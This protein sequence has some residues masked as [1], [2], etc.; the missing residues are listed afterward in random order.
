[1]HLEILY[2]SQIKTK[3]SATVRHRKSEMANPNNNISLT[4]LLLKTLIVLAEDLSL[5]LRT[6]MV[7]YSYSQ[8]QFQSIQYLLLTSV[9]TK[10]KCVT[11]TYIQKNTTRYKQVTPNNIYI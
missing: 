1:M 2:I 6:H 11:I 5:V 10:Q 7:P 3:M 9:F 8:P 4:S